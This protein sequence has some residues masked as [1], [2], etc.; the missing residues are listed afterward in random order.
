MTIAFR[1]NSRCVQ[2]KG[3]LWDTLAYKL[4]E[5]HLPFLLKEKCHHMHRKGKR[6]HLA[7]V[8]E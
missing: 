2:S 7:F 5:E 4:K 6:S 8:L 3:I 1:S